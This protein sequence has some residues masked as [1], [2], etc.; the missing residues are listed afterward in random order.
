MQSIPTQR[1]PL[2]ASCL[3]LIMHARPNGRH[4]VRARHTGSLPALAPVP[5]EHNNGPPALIDNDD[6]PHLNPSTRVDC[7]RLTAH[8]SHL[9]V[10][11]KLSHF[12]AHAG[13]SRSTANAGRQFTCSRT[14]RGRGL[15]FRLPLDANAL[16]ETRECPAR[17]KAGFRQNT[18]SCGE[19]PSTTL[20]RWSHT[21]ARHRKELA[22]PDCNHATVFATYTR[23]PMQVDLP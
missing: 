6:F 22:R 21:L 10:Y 18:V 2:A 11:T 12:L 23:P 9:V 17:D 1:A 4:S 7:S 15:L 19:C 3:L 14:S 16:C 13:I 20:E 5:C 8:H